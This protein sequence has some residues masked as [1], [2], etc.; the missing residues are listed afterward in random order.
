MN[1]EDAAE[2][3]TQIAEAGGRKC[4]I[5]MIANTL[6]YSVIMYSRTQLFPEHLPAKFIHNLPSGNMP[7]EMGDS[8]EKPDETLPGT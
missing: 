3:A 8:D 4:R 5:A 7:M 1:V 2:A 6:E